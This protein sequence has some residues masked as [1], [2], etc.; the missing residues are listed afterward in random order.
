[1]AFFANSGSVSSYPERIRRNERLGGGEDSVAGA[2]SGNWGEVGGSFLKTS[3]TF[4]GLVRIQY[5][6]LVPITG[7][8]FLKTARTLTWVEVRIIR[9]RSSFR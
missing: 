4:T 2:R 6:E 9:S 1:M 7:G 5:L 8:R 3:H